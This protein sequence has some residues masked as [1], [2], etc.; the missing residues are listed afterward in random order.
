MV[1]ITRLATYKR[2]Y[3][4]LIYAPLRETEALRKR[5]HI[6]VTGNFVHRSVLAFCVQKDYSSPLGSD[7]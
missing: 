6:G 5:E 2:E 4:R 1:G 7:A 3:M